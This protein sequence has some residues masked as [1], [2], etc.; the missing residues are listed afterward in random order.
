MMTGMEALLRIK[1]KY[2][3]LNHEPAVNESTEKNPR[4]IR[5]LICYYSQ[6]D[7]ST[8]ELYIKEEERADFYLQK[9]LPPDELKSLLKL[10]N[11]L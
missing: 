4:I 6:L 8:M 3:A 1:Q 5:P 11:I 7:R 9:P 10:I 2:E